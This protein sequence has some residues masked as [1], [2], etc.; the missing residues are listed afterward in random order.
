MQSIIFATVNKTKSFI[1]P[2]IICHYFMHLLYFRLFFCFLLSFSFL[3]WHIFLFIGP[4]R[5]THLRSGP[6]INLATKASNYRLGP[7][8]MANKL[9]NDS[10]LNNNRDRPQLR[11]LPGGAL[12]PKGGR[13][14]RGYLPKNV[15][16]PR[17]NFF[18]HTY[19]KVFING[20]KCLL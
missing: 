2:Q 10:V 11:P 9:I 4:K 5:G 6:I 18:A 3:F 17:A 8:T 12:P 15:V 13:N 16:R 1:M 19:K 14:G 7:Q 20:Q